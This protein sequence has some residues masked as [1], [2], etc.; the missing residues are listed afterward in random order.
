MEIVKIGAHET[1]V[2]RGATSPRQA[3]VGNDTKNIHDISL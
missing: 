3:N 1:W 2:P